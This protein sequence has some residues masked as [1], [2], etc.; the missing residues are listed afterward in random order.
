[1]TIAASDRAKRAVAR[2]A[3]RLVVDGTVLGL[4]SG[5]TAAYLVEA[6]A[7]RM[8]D[9]KLRIRGVP[10]SRRTEEI[11]RR[12]DIPIVDLS[13]DTRIDLAIDGADEIELGS[14]ALIKGLGGAL[15]RE[16]IV[17]A[18]AARFV[19][20][21]DDSK[22]VERL[23][24]RSPLPVEVISFGHDVTAG[25]LEELGGAPILRRK[26]DGAPF[27]S[28]GGNLIYDCAGFAP[29][30]DPRALEERLAS[31]VG[32]IESGLFIA[33]AAEALVA[34]AEEHVRHLTPLNIETTTAPAVR[35]QDR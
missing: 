34:D 25:Y 18:A 6:L 33:M 9:E 20:I 19:V 4:G 30:E 2:A 8:R 31:V 24:M 3:A 28:D 21:A 11:A 23:G 13:R 7:V 1:M 16:K 15:L 12:L 35:T 29:I 5:T 17:A 14:L 32:I 22:L 10:T 27:V 26:T